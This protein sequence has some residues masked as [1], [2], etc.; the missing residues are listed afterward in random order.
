MRFFVLLLFV[1]AFFAS[2]NSPAVT[3]LPGDIIVTDEDAQSGAGAIIH[4]NP[5]TGV[6]TVI[7]SGGDFV[8]PVDVTIEAN[9]KLLV[10]DIDAF[11]EGAILRVD[12]ATGVQTTVSSGGFFSTP[13]ALTLDVSGEILVADSGADGVIRVNPGNGAQLLVSSYKQQLCP[14]SRRSILPLVHGQHRS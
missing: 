4:V 14:S 2:T 3:L 11:A 10:S 8:N 9:G 7:S 1:F 12:P 13:N 6:Q 5:V